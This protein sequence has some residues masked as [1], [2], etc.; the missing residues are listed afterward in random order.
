MARTYGVPPEFKDTQSLLSYIT[1]KNGEKNVWDLV[2]YKPSTETIE[3]RMFGATDNKENI[4][5]FVIACE[6]VFKMACT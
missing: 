1:S 3:F 6:E 2:R 5:T 4:R